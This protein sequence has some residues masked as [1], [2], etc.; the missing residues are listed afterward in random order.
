MDHVVLSGSRTA[1]GPVD[2][3]ASTIPGATTTLKPLVVLV[4]SNPVGLQDLRAI[5]GRHFRLKEYA[6]GEQAW[7]SLQID[8]DAAA[9]VCSKTLPRMG[10]LELVAKLRKARLPSLR[11]IPVCLLA[12]TIDDN[13]RGRIGRQQVDFLGAWDRPLVDLDAWL[14]DRLTPAQPLVRRSRSD[15]LRRWAHQHAALDRK[16]RES[17]VIFR[18]ASEGVGVLSERLARAIRRP[19]MMLPDAL[20]CVWI[21]ADVPLS[22][23]LRFAMRLALGSIRDGDRDQARI[24]VSYAPQQ[25]L[26]DETYDV[27]QTLV[28]E[29]PPLKH[30]LVRTHHWKFVMPFDA[31]RLLVK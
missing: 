3:Q 26:A 29:E 22:S 7:A 30:I 12:D 23:A 13:L 21:C 20:N 15:A 8:G 5:L 25:Q 28:D 11:A 9:I 14:R 6:S 27:L 17:L 1:A 31:A 19:E 24:S 16:T 4:A 10:G 2:A 18:V